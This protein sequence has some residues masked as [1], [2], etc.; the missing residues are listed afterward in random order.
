MPFDPPV[1]TYRLQLHPSFPFASAVQVV[2]YLRQLGI[3]HVY[4]SPIWAATPGSTHGYDVVDHARIN[5]EL[6]GLAGFYALAQAVRDQGMQLILD[7]VPNHVGIAHHPWWRDVLRYG[8]HSQFAPYFDIDWEGQPQQETGV[9]V[10][11]VLGQPFGSALEAGELTLAYDDSEIVVRYYDRTF[12]VAPRL[13][14]SLLGL[15]P[16]GEDPEPVREVIATLESLTSATPQSAELLLSHL[17]ETLATAPELRRWLDG[18]VASYN[19]QVGQPESFNA[20]EALL[21][22][23]HYRLAYWR[24]SAEEINYRRFFDI[25]DLAAVRIEHEPAFEAT[26]SLVR[27]L[28]TAGLASGLRVDHVDGL[29]DPAG[30]L[31]RLRALSDEDGEPAIWVEKILGLGE[32]LPAH[33]PI[34]GTTGYEFLATAGGL[35]VDPAAEQAFSAIYEDFTESKS[36]FDDIAFAAR[37]RVAGRSFAG[38]VNVLALHLYRLAQ[39]RRLARDN[40]LGALREAIAALLSAMPVYRTYLESDE[41]MP[42]DAGII[43]GAAAEAAR[44]DPNITPES[45][46]FLVQVLML[47]TGDE[48]DEERARWVQFRRRFQ[49]LSSPVMAKGIEDTS[50]FRYH[51]LLALNEVGDHPAHFG[52]TAS[53]AHEWFGR[54]A[55]EWPGCLSGTTTHDTKRSEDARM[56]LAALTANPRAWH[57]EVRSWARSNSR[58]VRTQGDSPVPDRNTEYYLYQTLIAS[59]EG[60]PNEAYIA[61]IQAHMVKASREAKVHTSWTKVDEEYEAMLCEFVRAIL[62]RRRSSGFIRRLGEFVGT[63]DLVARANSLGLL[64][65]KAT[66]PGIPDFYQ[67]SEFSLYTLTD[68]DNR[69]DVDFVAAANRLAAI[70]AE[71]PRYLD[72]AAK[73]WLTRQLLALR[74]RH[75]QHFHQASY[76]RLE[77][78]GPLRDAAFAFE[79][80]SKSVRSITVVAIRAA[81]F[82]GLSGEFPGPEAAQTVLD[83]PA[84]WRWTDSLTGAAL[85]SGRVTLAELFARLPVA[86]LVAETGSVN[87]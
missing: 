63:L 81:Q 41:P 62:D 16:L 67:G 7:I 50:F 48:A 30:Y 35:F 54:R 45:L 22:Q 51:R 15:P 85:D 57:R 18:R 24:V 42:A 34:E 17:A 68:P 29:Y 10:Y 36:R 44:R 8:P 23:Q 25:N 1:A 55:N 87:A 13:Y 52:I 56:R 71:V 33:W 43:R 49:Q 39:A 74:A 3:S 61:R 77:L 11:P 72:T 19:G 40:T 46:S 78:Q 66:A 73:P 31:A 38:E 27:E 58:Q 86:I 65:L 2:P 47:N 32:D 60:R 64:A 20:L 6:G 70:P 14:S 69:Q 26:H 28:V 82:Y 83:L 76:R 79:R 80:Q 75:T 4:L 84:G 9:L 21:R 37:R 53:A 59:W 12:P 5:E